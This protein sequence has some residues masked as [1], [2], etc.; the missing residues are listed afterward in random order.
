MRELNVEIFLQVRGVD[1]RMTAHAGARPG[2]L[3]DRFQVG[4]PEG[5]AATAKL[6]QRVSFPQRVESG[7]ER[8]VTVNH[9]GAGRDQGQAADGHQRFF[10]QQAPPNEQP[11]TDDRRGKHGDYAA[12]G[13]GQQTGESDQTQTDRQRVLGHLAAVQRTAAGPE[14]GLRRSGPQAVQPPQQRADAQGEKVSEVILVLKRTLDNPI[15]VARRMLVDPQELA[16]AKQ[17]LG[18]AQH[19]HSNG[20]QRQPTHQPFDVAFIPDPLDQHQ[21][22]QHMS[23]QRDQAAARRLRRQGQLTPHAQLRF[24][25]GWRRPQRQEGADSRRQRAQH[26][27]R[28]RRQLQHDQQHAGQ[29]DALQTR[30]TPAGVCSADT[31]APASR[32]TS[33]TPRPRRPDGRYPRARP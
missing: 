23:D 29:E 33:S 14:G 18:Q 32:Q 3:G 21:E 17:H 2:E 10:A 15:G 28:Q 9:Q 30:P 12:A 4:G 24:R 1:V 13:E 19:G 22:Q 7:G 8:L 26:G 20:R 11:Q 16:V 6:V 5:T 25:G 27:R 31:A